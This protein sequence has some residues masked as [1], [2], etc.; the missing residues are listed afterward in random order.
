MSTRSAST[1]KIVAKADAKR[2]VSKK[3]P[4]ARAGAPKA[5]A[6]KSAKRVPAKKVA[7][8]VAKAPANPVPPRPTLKAQLVENDRL[9]AKTGHLFGL[10]RMPRKEADP[11]IYEAVWQ[12]LQNLCDAAWTVGC[13]VSASPIAAEGG[14]ALWGLHLSLIHISEPTRPY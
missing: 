4:A 1:R 7:R 12:I 11:G 3:G 2:A 13:K 14:D 9:L 6:V 8:P 5:K 10:K